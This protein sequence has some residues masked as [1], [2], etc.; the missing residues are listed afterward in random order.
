MTYIAT[1]EKKKNTTV[2]ARDEA[3]RDL[4]RDAEEGPAPAAPSP[5]LPEIISPTVRAAEGEG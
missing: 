2:H 3:G 4:N 5:P 1:K